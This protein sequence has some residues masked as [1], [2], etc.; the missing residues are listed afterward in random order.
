MDM[1]GKLAALDGWMDW[2]D[3]VERYSNVWK[4]DGRE[5]RVVVVQ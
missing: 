2:E 5:D 3:W 1:E 4:W